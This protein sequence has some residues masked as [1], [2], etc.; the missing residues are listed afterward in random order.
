MKKTLSLLCLFLG[1]NCYPQ[2]DKDF[3]TEY[4]SF[5]FVSKPSPNSHLAKFLAEHID[6]KELKTISYTTRKAAL[7]KIIRLS[8]TLTGNGK[9]TNF[10]IH[11]GNDKLN[12]KLK[13]LFKTY[14]LEKLGIKR[15]NK[16]GKYSVQLFSKE[17]RKTI[18]NSSS[19]AVYDVPP[20]L[21][22]CKN[23][24]R[25]SRLTSC[26]YQGLNKHIVQNFSTEIFKKKKLKKTKSIH[27]YPLFS[28]NLEGK[29]YNINE[30]NFKF[31]H[32]S[33]RRNYYPPSK[34]IQ[35]ELNRVIRSFN[36]IEVPATRNG[37]PKYFNYD[38]FYILTIEKNDKE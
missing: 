26:F 6:K 4:D 10:R 29:I 36:L 27:I 21:N 3:K 37:K 33:N 23:I 13:S 17:K 38:T 35:V 8:F 28:V 2:F 32:Y 11:T 14:P 24:K 15:K 7:K 30:I 22:S 31:D 1:L 16:L 5:Q 34:N 20:I 9:P 19:I 18:I 12:K 25:Y